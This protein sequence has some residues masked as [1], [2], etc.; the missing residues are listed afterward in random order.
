MNKKNTIDLLTQIL[1]KLPLFIFCVAFISMYNNFFGKENSIVGV[2]ILMS[3]LIFLSSNLDINVKQASF[4]IPVLFLVIGIFPKV[5]L[6]NPFIGIIVNFITMMILLIITSSNQALGS[7]LPFAMG[8]IM[9]EGYDVTGVIFTKRIISLIVGGILIGIIYYFFNSKDT[10]KKTIKNLFSEININNTNTQWQ[11]MLSTAISLTW[12]AGDIFSFPKTMWI[13]LTVLS[14][15]CPINSDFINRQKQRIPATIIGCILFFVIFEYLIPTQ[16]QPMV[17][18][19]AGFLSMFI[20]SYFIKTIYNSFSALVT[21]V[22]L[23]P[24]T[25][26]VMLRIVANIIGVGVSLLI[27]YI[28]VK[29]FNLEQIRDDKIN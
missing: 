2:I 29:L 1:K 5:A 10:N 14:L 11:I 6:I 18:L 22:L 17:I 20:N 12:F 8:F 26:A 27:S 7:Y 24:A 9:F 13:A 16:S 28:F 21:A 15:I 4:I 19:L 23:F 3:L 25:D